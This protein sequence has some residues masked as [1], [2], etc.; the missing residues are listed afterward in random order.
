MICFSKPQASEGVEKRGCKGW[1]GFGQGFFLGIFA[2]AILTCGILIAGVSAGRGKLTRS[3]W[4][5]DAI[6]MRFSFPAHVSL[7]GVSFCA[8]ASLTLLGL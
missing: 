7:F 8:I 1:A 4:L 6:A 2:Q 5:A 3:M